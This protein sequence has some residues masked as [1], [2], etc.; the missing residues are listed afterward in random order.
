MSVPAAA[1]PSVVAPATLARQEAFRLYTVQQEAN[2][3]SQISSL[4]GTGRVVGSAATT[5]GGGGYSVN[6]LGGDSGGGVKS[7]EV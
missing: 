7:E 1:V 5:N 3:T 6:G 4:I 2:M